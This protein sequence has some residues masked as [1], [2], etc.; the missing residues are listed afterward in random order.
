[1]RSTSSLHHLARSPAA[2]F[3]TLPILASCTKREGDGEKAGGAQVAV[4]AKSDQAAQAAKSSDPECI[5]AWN[6]AGEVQKIAVGGRTFERTGTKLV[7]TS[8][9]EADQVVLG[10]LANTKE[11]TEENLANIDQ[12]LKFFA[13]EGAEAI[14][15]AGDVGETKDQMVKVLQPIAA[16]GLPT[17]VVIG[18]R[19][20]KSDFNA[21]LAEVSAQHPG[22]VNMSVVR[23]AVLD[24]VALVSV[25]GY[26]DRAYIHEEDGCQYTAADLEASRPIVA[27]AAGKPVVLVSHGPPKQ[28]GAE[29]L[30][31]TLEQGNVGDPALAKFIRDTQVKFGIFAN[32]Q[33]AGGRAT[34]LSGA[35]LVSPGKLSP[36]LFLN[37]GAADSV[38][39]KMNDGTRSA[40]MA[41]VMIVKGGQAS[42]KPFRVPGGG[43]E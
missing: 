18:N 21:A 40:G 38:S 33:E 32:I 31:R 24:D 5:S 14:V 4:T 29:A 35:R 6:P 2:L 13:A 42:F 9:T 1:M 25:P 37:P 28:E 43:D 10:V 22:V 23:L 3:L 36:E 16:R 8:K 26:Y 15:L 12:I 30:D 39:W 19:E 20:K 34:D 41:A 17:F 11:D 7:E 27:A